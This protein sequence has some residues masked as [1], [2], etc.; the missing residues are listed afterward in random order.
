MTT[1]N[2]HLIRDKRTHAVLNNDVVGLTAYK[3]KRDAVLRAQQAEKRIDAIEASVENVHK[4][5]TELK[6]L[7]LLLVK[8][9]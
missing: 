5:I 8:R 3:A 9:T 7:V 4:E 6:E 1:K 2:P